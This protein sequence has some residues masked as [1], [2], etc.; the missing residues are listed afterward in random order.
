MGYDYRD[1]MA[2]EVLN[3]NFLRYPAP[4]SKLLLLF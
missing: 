1:K 4:I 3:E 2:Y